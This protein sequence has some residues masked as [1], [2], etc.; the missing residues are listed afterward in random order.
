MK[1]L[2]Q[3][4]DENPDVYAW[5]DGTLDYCFFDKEKSFLSQL[6]QSKCLNC[7]TLIIE[8]NEARLSTMTENVRGIQLTCSKCGLNYF[9]HQHVKFDT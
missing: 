3:I 4:L 2:D 9:L 6:M 8:N 5:D 7:D 1:T